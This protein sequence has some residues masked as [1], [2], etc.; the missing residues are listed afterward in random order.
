[1]GRKLNCGNGDGQKNEQESQV[2]TILFLGYNNGGQ[3]GGKKETG[4]D[5]KGKTAGAAAIR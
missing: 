2:K 3:V 4:G 1:L 5:G